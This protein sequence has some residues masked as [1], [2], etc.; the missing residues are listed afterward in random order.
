V[1][2]F[3]WIINAANNP[4]LKSGITIQTG[5]SGIE[6]VGVGCGVAVWVGVVVGVGAWVKIGAA[7]GAAVGFAVGAGVG[8]GAALTVNV[9][10][11]PFLPPPV[12]EIVAPVPALLTETDPVQTPAT[13]AEVLVGLIVPREY[14]RAFVPT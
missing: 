7:V 11:V 3:F 2:F 12:V 6:G 1:R 5:N 4:A 14:V 9:P 13:K 10:L 8:V